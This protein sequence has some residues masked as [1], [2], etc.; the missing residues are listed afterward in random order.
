MSKLENIKYGTMIDNQ[1]VYPSAHLSKS[2]FD[3]LIKQVEKVEGLE[4]EIKE[5]NQEIGSY[6]GIVEALSEELGLL[7]GRMKIL[8]NKMLN[9]K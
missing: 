8:K 1:G 5:L 2:D 9:S 3:W 7:T 6:A 4:K